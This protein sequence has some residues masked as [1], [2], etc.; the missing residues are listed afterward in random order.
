MKQWPIL[1]IV[2]VAGAL[3]CLATPIVLT[4]LG[5][6]TLGVIAGARF[7]PLLLGV[8]A[9]TAPALGLG[10]YLRRRRGDRDRSHKKV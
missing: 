10:S 3:C 2:I 9:L 8:T 1:S 7:W 6:A 5:G 4:L